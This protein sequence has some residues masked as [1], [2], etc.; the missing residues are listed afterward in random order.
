MNMY[1]T[2]LT[3][4]KPHGLHVQLDRHILAQIDSAGLQE[5]WNASMDRATSDRQ[6]IDLF[7]RDLQQQEELQDSELQDCVLV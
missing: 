3:I 4:L 1:L 2:M 7:L 6:A 5:L